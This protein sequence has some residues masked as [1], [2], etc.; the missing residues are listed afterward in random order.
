MSLG[1]S[2]TLP[3][4]C[5]RRY[6]SGRYRGCIDLGVPLNATVENAVQSYR[7]RRHINVS[8]RL[9]EDVIMRLRNHGLSQ[10]DDVRLWKVHNRLSTGD[11]MFKWNSNTDTKCVLCHCQIKTRDHL[12]FSCSFTEEIWKGLTSEILGTRYTQ[13]WSRILELIMGF[14]KDKTLLFLLRYVFQSTVYSI[15]WERNRR[16][17]GETSM[18]PLQIQKKMINLFEIAYHLSGKKEEEDMKML[19]LCGS[20]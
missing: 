12:F 17:H 3:A 1:H 2:Q 6:G 15:W 20:V 9:I 13:E 4:T 16:R 5:S 18:D 10:Q 11:R 7:R 19:W 8:L 14:S